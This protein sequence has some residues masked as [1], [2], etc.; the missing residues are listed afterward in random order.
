MRSFRLAVVSIALLML[1]ACSYPEQRWKQFKK[2]FQHKIE[3]TAEQRKPPEEKCRQKGGTFYDG[4]CYTPDEN[5]SIT[6]EQDC[7]MRGGMYID[8]ECLFAPR[9]K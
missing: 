5:A 4:Q 2:D 6:D 9:Q 3:Q 1:P 7:H 8:D